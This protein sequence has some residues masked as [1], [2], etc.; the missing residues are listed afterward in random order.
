MLVS[1]IIPTYKPQDYLWECLEALMA[2]TISKEDFEVILVLNG[3]NEPYKSAIDRY[4]VENTQGMNVK[5]IQTEVGGVSNARNIGIDSAC[6]EFVSFVDDDDIVSP[7]YLEE[8]LSVSSPDC[9]GCANSYAFE[10]DI[11]KFSF[12]FISSA[13][14]KCKQ[15]PFTTFNY[16]SYLSPPWGKLIHKKIINTERFSTKLKKGEDGLFCFAIS[17][18][19][20]EMRLT[21]E[22]AIYFQRKRDGSVMRRKNSVMNELI[23]A[24]RQEKVL[25]SL[26]IKYPSSYN[27]PYA[28][29]RAV[30]ILRNFF[31][32][33]TRK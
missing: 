13:Y 1:V 14:E 10:N 29:S 17:T 4:I 16:R 22:S 3:C 21:S 30:G 26:W 32:Y 15:R 28:V 12:N 23:E 8:L 2:Q 9:V 7:T 31:I 20:K 5:F 11:T 33:V 25:I 24:F 27:L 18:N 19:I 6:G